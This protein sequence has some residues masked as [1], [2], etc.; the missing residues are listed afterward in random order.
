MMAKPFH[1]LHAL[2][3]T[4]KYGLMPYKLQ[5]QA[6]LL[7]QRNM[8]SSY[9]VSYSS[10]GEPEARTLL[11]PQCRSRV[12]ERA[13]LPRVSV[14]NVL[15]LPQ[16]CVIHHTVVNSEIMGEGGAEYRAPCEEDQNLHNHDTPLNHGQFTPYIGSLQ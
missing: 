3:T 7:S 14:D 2:T 8:A 1:S 9:C 4:Q 13:I 16:C 15:R 12:L 5:V 6:L 10:M 11:F